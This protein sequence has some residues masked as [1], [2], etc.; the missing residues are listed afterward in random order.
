MKK[1]V[2]SSY[3][4]IS[5]LKYIEFTMDKLND[6]EVLI[7]NKAIGVNFIDIYHRKGI[8]K[9]D[10]PFTP[11][12]EGAGIII[13]AG[14]KL[15]SD[16][17]GKRVCYV[18]TPGAYSSH[19][20]MKTKNLIIIPDGITFKNAASLILQGMTAHY[21][22]N[23]TCRLK[24]N[25]TILLHAAGGGVGLIL[26]Q[27]SKLKKLNV[28]GTTS[29]ANKEDILK[30]Q[31]C[32]HVI[33]YDRQDFLSETV[34]ITKQAGVDV[35]FDSV[36]ATTFFKSLKCL[37]PKGLLVSFGQSAGKIPPFDILELSKNGSLFITRPTLDDYIRTSEE[38][39]KRSNDIFS[40][41][42]SHGLSRIS[43][44]EYSLQEA[45]LAHKKLESRQN[46]GKIVLIP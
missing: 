4:D 46:I 1:I 8:Y 5:V 42:L 20:K 3:G 15:S 35:V 36:G 45:G 2:I 9:P 22:I 21:L 10:L 41:F 28:I 19:I 26:L 25:D 44:N 13:D 30:Q 23:D 16:Y 39:T 29:S 31:G 11:G 14:K 17:I 27:L 32:D 12:I 24:E 38:L 33:R 18:N 34:R 40:L 43:C 7:E 37:K 6:D